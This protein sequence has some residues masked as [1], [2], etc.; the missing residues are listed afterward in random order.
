MD[1]T[2][3]VLQLTKKMMKKDFESFS[4][5]QLL[6]F[7]NI[8]CKYPIGA[9]KNFLAEYL[10]ENSEETH[11]DLLQKLAS[12]KFGCSKAFHSLLRLKPDIQN[13]SFWQ[14]KGKEFIFSLNF[15]QCFF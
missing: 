11:L 3:D 8:T 7:V 15:F 13:Q 5:E 14:E 4:T 9:L 6:K 2:F 12:S 1:D 10:S